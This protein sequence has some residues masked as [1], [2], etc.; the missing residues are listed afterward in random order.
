MGAE[1][2]TGRLIDGR[3]KL[4]E[5]LGSGAMGS[6]YKARDTQGERIVA[7][8]ILNNDV[9]MD[10]GLHSRFEREGKILAGLDHRHIVT[11]YHFGRSE[12]EQSYFSMEYLEGKTL[13]Q[14]LGA[15]KVLNW[16]RAL[17]I[18][19][20]LCDALAYAHRKGVIHRDLKPENII[21]LNLPEADFV[22]LVDFGLAK[23]I[24][25]ELNSQKLTKTGQLLGTLKYIS[26]EQC[27]GQRSD[28]RSDIYSL[29][30]IIYESLLGSPPFTS[31]NPM[32]VVFKHANEEARDFASFEPGKRIPQRLE[33]VL[34]KAMKKSPLQRYQNMGE[35]QTALTEILAD[36]TLSHDT[37]SSDSK[38]ALSLRTRKDLAAVTL[39]AFIP[40]LF[41]TLYKNIKE[42]MLDFGKDKPVQIDARPS[43]S[44]K[45]IIIKAKSSLP[46][47]RAQIDSILASP[48]KLAAD[49]KSALLLIRMLHEGRN[50]ALIDAAKGLN[51]TPYNVNN[52]CLLVWKFE[53]LRCL[54]NAAAEIAAPQIQRKF[55]QANIDLQEKF[56]A[57]PYKESRGVYGSAIL[58]Q[59]RSAMIVLLKQMGYQKEALALLE[60]EAKNPLSN[61]T[62]LIEAA[63]RLNRLDIVDNLIPY[64]D[65]YQLCC[66]FREKGLPERAFQCAKFSTLIHEDDN[67]TPQI[68]RQIFLNL[69]DS[70]GFDSN[71]R[72]G[73]SR[74]DK[75]RDGNSKGGVEKLTEAQKLLKA[76][77]L[78]RGNKK[79][80]LQGLSISKSH[81]IALLL[82]TGDLPAAKELLQRCLVENLSMDKS[83]QAD[84]E[85]LS[86]DFA[87]VPQEATKGLDYLLARY[88]DKN[89]SHDRKLCYAFESFRLLSQ[90]K[91]RKAAISDRAR[92]ET[93]RLFAQSLTSLYLPNLQF[94]TL[95]AIVDDPGAE[96]Y[97]IVSPSDP[98]AKSAVPTRVKLGAD[99]GVKP[100]AVLEANTGAVRG[101]KPGAKLVD[102]HDHGPANDSEVDLNPLSGL[103][104]KQWAELS[105]L[106]TYLWAGQ[107]NGELLKLVR[108]FESDTMNLPVQIKDQL[109]LV[110]LELGRDK[111]AKNLIETVDDPFLVF[112]MLRQSRARNRTELE[113][114][115]FKKLDTMKLTAE[116]KISLKLEKAISNLNSGHDPEAR[117][118]LNQI[119]SKSILEIPAK[120]RIRLVRDLCAALV[121]AKQENKAEEL[122]KKLIAG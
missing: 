81:W 104:Y 93:K 108:K 95:K 77:V 74:V 71:K 36:E 90:A 106:S 31:D 57:A 103:N 4:I 24:S 72:S 78:K 111:E 17:K 105:C 101:A 87:N 8:K 85:Q 19:V 82:L 112:S 18:A 25:A 14:I 113:K 33:A 12:T 30:C 114:F 27:S 59:E 9:F 94:A 76:N 46:L 34:K 3:F 55:K 63:Y 51:I 62:E 49:Q 13:R 32:T 22:K 28:E 68:E 118:L 99:T 44:A 23:N 21:L 37:N 56:K 89:A 43:T 107:R 79:M 73:G 102:V 122:L 116:Q 47:K 42:G 120:K 96:I 10:L 54:D 45:E 35:F 38:F 97:L 53:A 6:V 15:E 121:F 70:Q 52:A 69:I 91:T 2:L 40:V 16:Q 29:G 98:D 83:D 61:K 119:S 88:Q 1:N 58:S 39:L 7:I 64:S 75:N 110:Q 115:C 66:F 117:E 20:Q 48:E 50:A 109:F 60:T 11:F 65:D 86:R 5:S 100:G 84:L 41:F 80:H 67:L 26:P 92:L